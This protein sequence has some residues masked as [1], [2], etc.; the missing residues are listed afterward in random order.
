MSD[1][2]DTT[3]TSTETVSKGDVSASNE[4]DQKSA[5]K[6]K[7]EG[8]TGSKKRSVEKPLETAI[9][10]RLLEFKEVPSGCPTCGI[11]FTLPKEYF[12]RRFKDGKHFYC[13]NGH[14]MCWSQE[15]SAEEKR[16]KKALEA[17]EAKVEELENTIEELKERIE[18]ASKWIASSPHHKNCG[19]GVFNPC[20]CG[21]SDFV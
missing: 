19:R 2:A 9:L 15:P 7:A 11:Q 13:P 21:R 12:D 1:T 6:A 18:E 4:V 3:E 10:N 14:Y 5:K 8:D 16:L 17:S 20:S